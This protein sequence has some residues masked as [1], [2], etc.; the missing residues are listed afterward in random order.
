MITIKEYKM[1]ENLEQAYNLYQQRNNIIIG[2]MMWIKM[3]NKSINTAIDLSNLGLNQITETP[4]SFI[5]GAMTP[6]RQIETH[7]GLR[8]FFGDGLYESLRHIV[9]TQFRNCATIGGS[10]YM[11]FGFSDILTSLMALDAEVELYKKGIISLEEYAK[12]PKDRDILVNI[13]IKKKPIKMS[14][15]SLRN[16]ETDFP[17][18]SCAVSNNDKG[19]KA[20]I[21][22]RP[23]QA[24]VVYD[25]ENILT[26]DITEEKA[27]LFSEYVKKNLDF[28]TNRRASGA[29]RK[30]IAGVL[31]KRCIL[32]LNGGN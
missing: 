5:I 10:I 32:A 25:K 16:T 26:G 17:V 19:Y 23:L 4:E 9:G 31:T 8:E 12:Q 6:L 13:I 28:H 21:G 27:K 15:M 3:Q 14:Y 2:G 18:L 20:V 22:A 24:M 30:H 11:R 7:K 29:Y 1:V